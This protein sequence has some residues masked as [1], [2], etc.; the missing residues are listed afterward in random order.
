MEKQQPSKGDPTSVA[1]NPEVREWE[2]EAEGITTTGTKYFLGLDAPRSPS[3][4]PPPPSVSDSPSIGILF[5]AKGREKT[6]IGIHSKIS[7]RKREKK[8]CKCIRAKSTSMGDNERNK[9]ATGKKHLPVCILDANLYAAG[10]G[11]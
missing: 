6:R 11:S 8:K 10:T 3:L 9:A 2:A 4:H 5:S 1:S 7:K